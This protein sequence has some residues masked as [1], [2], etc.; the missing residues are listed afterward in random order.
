MNISFDDYNLTGFFKTEVNF[1]GIDAFLIEPSREYKFDRKHVIFRSSVW[2]KD[3]VLLSAGFKKFTNFGENETE[4]PPP[5][6]LSGTSIVEKL[7]GSLVCID[8]VNNTLNMRTRGTSTYK[9]HGNN[10]EFED[11]LNKYKIRE[12]I[13]NNPHYT[14]LFESTTPTNKIIIDYGDTPDFVL[15]GVVN[16]NDYSLLTQTKLDEIAVEIGIRRPRRYMFPSIIDMVEVVSNLPDTEGVCLYSNNDQDIH[17]VKTKKYIKLH[18]LKSSL[19]LNALLDV[20]I[21]NKYTTYSELYEYVLNAFDYEVAEEV[22]NVINSIYNAQTCMESH[23]N[24]IKVV[25]SNI[26]K[27]FPT[28]KDRAIHIKK[29]YAGRDSALLFL[30]L[31][32]RQIPDKLKR[33]LL[34]QYIKD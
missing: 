18:Y 8:Y 14:L 34:R 12:Y 2:S 20:F 24:H 28:P 13:Q 30:Y 17:K 11:C 1:C 5:Q 10:K 29:M 32:N 26:E 25:A 3:G 27:E 33:D 31:N 9:V 21:E 6:S 23:L 15:I 22:K 16:K 19:S 4:F 7:D